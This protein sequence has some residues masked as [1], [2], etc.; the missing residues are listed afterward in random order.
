MLPV[1][2]SPETQGIS[3]K[4]RNDNVLG[5]FGRYEMVKRFMVIGQRVLLSSDRA[6]EVSINPTFKT[7][8]PS[9]HNNSILVL[10]QI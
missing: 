4:H 10:E 3:A 5:I 2:R 6:R 1:P 9:G 7:L 8:P